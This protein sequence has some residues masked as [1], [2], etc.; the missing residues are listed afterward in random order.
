MHDEEDK[1]AACLKGNSPC[2]GSA[3]YS[4]LVCMSCSRRRKKLQGLIATKNQ[5]TQD[6][7]ELI[8]GTARVKKW[9]DAADH[10]ACADYPSYEDRMNRQGSNP[11]TEGAKHLNN[12]SDRDSSTSNC[13]GPPCAPKRVSVSLFLV[14]VILYLSFSNVVNVY[15]MCCNRNEMGEF[16]V[17]VYVGRSS[18]G[19]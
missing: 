5:P 12:V 4:N 14:R 18:M 10:Q 15:Q 7:G 2:V 3:G 8:P 16:G 17:S 11:K 6:L 1:S 13:V 19:F 9:I